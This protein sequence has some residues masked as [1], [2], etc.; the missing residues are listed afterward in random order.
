MVDVLAWIVVIGVI[1]GVFIT[2]GW[3]MADHWIGAVFACL[4]VA[5]IAAFCWGVSVIVT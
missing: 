3:L 1:L 5:V 4:A 2:Y